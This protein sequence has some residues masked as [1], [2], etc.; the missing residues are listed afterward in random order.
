MS[1]NAARAAALL[2]VFSVIIPFAAMG[3]V[4]S[5]RDV[6]TP[7][8]Y[9]SLEPAARG[10][11]LQIAVVLQIRKGFHINAREA[12]A[13]YLIPTDLRAE[14]PAGFKSGQVIYPKGELHTFS[15]SKKPLNVYQDKVI[16]RVP[17]SVLSSAS[18]GTQRMLFKL[19]YQACS[20]DTCLPPVTVD[21]ETPVTVASNSEASH[22]AHP[23]LFP[24]R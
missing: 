11:S 10:N 24:G 6:V 22:P 7:S 15:F 13:D 3:Q 12:S 18:I 23:E 1:R 2:L 9:V 8:A 17:V 4:P 5:G 16:L 20:T 19:R 14:M 21:V